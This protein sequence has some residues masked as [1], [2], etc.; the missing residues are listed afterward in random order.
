[1]IRIRRL[2]SF[3]LPDFLLFFCCCCWP[4]DSM[5]VSGGA[6][7]FERI[8]EAAEEGRRISE[9]P[10][11]APAARRNDPV[12][13]AASFTLNFTE[14][15]PFPVSQPHLGTLFSPPRWYYSV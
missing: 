15:I 4:L 3:P 10:L 8:E 14:N 12:R 6:D 5:P 2:S 1:M 11:P 13:L 7:R 9:P